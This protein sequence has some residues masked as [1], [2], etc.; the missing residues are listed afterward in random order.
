[1]DVTRLGW[2]EVLDRTRSLSRGIPDGSRVW[3][4]PR[5]GGYVAAMIYG[6]GMGIERGIRV[7]STPEEATIAVDDVIESGRTLRKVG[8]RYGLTVKALIDKRKSNRNEWFIF[9]WE[10]GWEA[11]GAELVT[12]MIEMVGD[13]PT[14]A[15]LLET[16][17]RVVSAWRE[18]YAGYAYDRKALVQLLK[19][20]PAA[21]PVEVDANPI[22]ISD[23]PFNSTCEHHLMPF[24]GAVEVEYLPQDGRNGISNIPR[25]IDLISRKLQIQERFTQEIADVLSEVTTF[26]R[27]K[28]SASHACLGHLGHN[29]DGAVLTT[30]AEA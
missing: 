26:V 6:G 13:D 30:H 22:L 20:L 8:E 11:E 29:D 24:S 10:E 5:G 1:M 9:P 17:E 18:L 19:R 2:R 3:G 15:G 16:P 4:I 23:I 21:G 14:R 25:V 7:V 27:V 28:V 12:R